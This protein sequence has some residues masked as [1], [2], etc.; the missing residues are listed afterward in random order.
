MAVE[1]AEVKLGS[2][3]EVLD[4]FTQPLPIGAGGVMPNDREMRVIE[5]ERQ[6]RLAL[7][8]KSSGQ[9]EG[10]LGSFGKGVAMRFDGVR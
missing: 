1:G 10:L 7:A 6:G 3:V 5:A 4:G 8:F 9:G 2:R